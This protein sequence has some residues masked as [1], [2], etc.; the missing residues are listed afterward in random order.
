MDKVKNFQ[1]ENPFEG[2]VTIDEAASTV[3]RP[4]STVR[5]WVKEGRITA[6]RIGNSA[7][8]LVFLDEVKEY[9]KQ[10]LRYKTRKTDRD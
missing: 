3:N 1:I 9:S 7:I 2:W 8:R 10:A 4:H 6:Y 5:K